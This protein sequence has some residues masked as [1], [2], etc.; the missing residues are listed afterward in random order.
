MAFLL[1]IP[2]LRESGRVGPFLLELAERCVTAGDVRIVVVDDGSGADEVQ[3][4]TAL[5]NAVRTRFPCLE[6][7]LVLPENVGKGGAIYAAWDRAC[8][9]SSELHPSIWLGFVDADGSV[10]ASEVVRVL[11]MARSRGPEAGALFGSRVMLLGRKVERLWKRH[12]VGRVFATITSELLGIPVY[13]SQCG[14]K[15]VPRSAFATVRSSLTI[16]GFAFDV[17]LLVA[18]LD[19][20]CAVTEVPVDWHEVGGGK[21]KVMHDSWRMLR[22]VWRIRKHRKV[23]SVS[24]QSR[25]P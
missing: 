19:S 22:D 11:E 10:S 17:Q 3:R 20:G 18:L 25:L 13:D 14:F 7:L 8:V 12:L 21:V 4:M 1:V 6:P 5:V 2:C 9:A 23:E 16:S 24:F 15:L